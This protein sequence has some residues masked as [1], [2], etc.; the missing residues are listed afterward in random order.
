MAVNQEELREGRPWHTLTAAE[1]QR[2]LDTPPAGLTAAEAAARIERYGPNVVEAEK[3]EAWWRLLLRQFNDPLIFILLIAAAV[4]AALRDFTDSGVILAVVI[5]NAAIGFVQELRAREAIRGLAR[6]SAPRAE[7]QRDGRVHVIESRDLVPG[8]LVLLASGARVPADIR[9]ISLHDLELDESMLTG[10]SEPVR[11][12]DEALG[13]ENLVSSDQLNM[14]FAG[15]VATRGRGRGLVV[16]TGPATEIGRIATSIRAVGTTVTPLQA[17]MHRFGRRIGWAVGVLA[18]VVLIVGLLRG[19]SASEMFLTAV[20]LAVSAIPEGLPVV[21]TVTLAIGVG[22]M[23]RRQAIIRSLPAVETLGSTTVIG[24]DKTGT[25]TRNE[26][27]VTAIA[28][29]G[30]VFEMDDL[31]R[32][33]AALDERL[34]RILL[35]G[36]LAN[37]ADPAA[38]EHAEVQ[39]DPTEI[40]LL[41]AARSTGA[42]P[43][44]LRA[45]HPEV[46]VIP[47]EPEQRWMATLNRLPGDALAIFLKGAPEVVLERCDRQL[48]ARGTEEPIDRGAAATAARD[49]GARGLRVLAMAYRAVDREQLNEADMRDGFV[50]L[51]A[52][53]MEDPVRPEAV[54]AVRA[55]H[56]AGIRVLMLTGDHVDTARNV[57]S[58]L[59]LGAGPD[60]R[61]VE[62]SSLDS[63][64]DEE[65]TLI[66]RE[67]DV[68]ARVTPKHKLRLVQSLMA[69]GEIVAV[70]GDGVNDA[71]A[72]RAA[73]LGIAMGKGGTD[74]AREASDMIL[75]DD[76]FATITAA[77]EEGRTIFGNVR[78]VAFFLLSTA[79]AEVITILVALLA[80]W[81]LPFIAAQILWINLVTNGLQD[82]AL[83]FEKGEPGLLQRP[84]RRIREGIVTLR[85]LERLG[86][87]GIVLAAGTLA[88]FWWTLEQSGDLTHART[89]AMTQMVVFQFFHVFNCRSLDRS[90]FSIPLFSNRFLFISIITAAAAHVAVLHI[91]FLQDVFRTGPLRPTEWLLVAAVGSMA[92]IGGEMD[93]WRNR[94]KGRLL[95]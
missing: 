54:A 20:A 51:G 15:T 82:V 59:G 41:Q 13:T 79:V 45:R 29:G 85:I 47:F 24:S 75:A 10:E 19:L 6:L 28:A 2:L 17:E 25:L 55:A 62:G 33:P 58:Q 46:N 71:P 83:A 60:P 92:I 57:G 35:A 87:V 4:T 52:Q 27:T 30:R 90:V 26:M 32:E 38:L 81:P 9:L 64:T 11:K 66:I 53:G 84:P 3:V 63:L 1:V 86:A 70:T 89:M 14:A 67:V 36:V 16:R 44:E 18:V 91:G 21:M 12:S 48:T 23:A 77:I 68:Y 76:N 74:V 5:L 50:F 42:P 7:V 43:S 56:T 37:E 39:G 65:L 78:K 73:H 49:L 80:G 94:K 93:K 31:I 72:L 22:R 88:V 69:Q 34:R 40:A 61:A 8:D 95:G